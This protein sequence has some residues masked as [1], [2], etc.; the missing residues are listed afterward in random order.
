VADR[1][2]WQEAALIGITA[3]LAAGG[4]YWGGRQSRG[5][6]ETVQKAQFSHEANTQR[7]EA[8]AV[9]RVMIAEFDGAVRNLC[10]IGTRGSWFVAFVPMRTGVSEADRRLVANQME[11][12]KWHLVALADNRLGTWDAVQKG[13]V[14]AGVDPHDWRFRKII[15]RVRLGRRQLEG[16]ARY[17]PETEKRFRARCRRAAT[18]KRQKPR[19]CNKPSAVPPELEAT[20]AATYAACMERL[21]R[22]EKRLREIPVP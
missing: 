19:G 4:A 15:G 14:G 17:D 10:D 8:Q 11:S 16:V 13:V 22:R 1:P 7:Q 18:W 12:E 21:R 9:A 2:F 3:T 5:T 6:A 20:Y